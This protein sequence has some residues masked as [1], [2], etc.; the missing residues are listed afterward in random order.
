MNKIAPA[1]PIGS[2]CPMNLVIGRMEIRSTGPQV[3]ACPSNKEKT[4]LTPAAAHYVRSSE[5][6]A[7]TTGVAPSL[8]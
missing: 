4:C 5:Q 3:N 2:T 8:R 1:Y 7:Q 6:R